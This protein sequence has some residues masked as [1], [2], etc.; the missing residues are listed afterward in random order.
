[1]LPDPHYADVPHIIEGVN[2]SL[3]KLVLTPHTPHAD[4]RNEHHSFAR[5]F[6]THSMPCTKVPLLPEAID[7]CQVP[8]TP[9]TQSMT[10][11]SGLVRPLKF[12]RD[13]VSSLSILRGKA[14][15][16]HKLLSK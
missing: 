12:I 4:T 11:L 7:L 6:F 3:V 2:S 13:P 5:Y 9:L 8:E 10:C 14:S 16:N 1:M 15:T